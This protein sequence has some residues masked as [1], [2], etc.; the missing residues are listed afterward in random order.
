MGLIIKATPAKPIK[1]AGTVIDMTELYGR[2]EFAARADGRTLEI[3][4]G[5]YV[6][7]AT[8]LQGMPIYT[9]V[10]QGSFQVQLAD[11]EVQS[12]DTALEYAKKAYEQLGYNVEIV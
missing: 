2:I 12:L 9:D 10:Q 8:F 1:I 5:T 7:E 4:V 3:A 6:S 11:G